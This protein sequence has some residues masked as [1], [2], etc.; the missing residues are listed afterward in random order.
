MDGKKVERQECLG[1]GS[2]K[3]EYLGIHEQ[4]RNEDGQGD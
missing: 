4:R 2:I 1:R 3:S